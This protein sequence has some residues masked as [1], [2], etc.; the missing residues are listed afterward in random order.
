MPGFWTGVIVGGLVIGG[1]AA[2]VIYQIEKQPIMF[3]SKVVTDFGNQFWFE[4]SIYS[5]DKSDNRPVNN[6]I[7]GRCYQDRMECDLK[8]VDQIGNKQVGSMWEETI[9]IRSWDKR[10]IVADSLG[11]SAMEEQ[12]NWYEIRVDRATE[13]IAYNRYPNPK[14]KPECSKFSSERIFR[15]KIDNGYGWNTNSDGSPRR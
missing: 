12:C 11:L 3:P 13:N 14:A 7:H 6:L 8:T 10:K 2:W 4:G 5:A 9:P 15:W 1:G